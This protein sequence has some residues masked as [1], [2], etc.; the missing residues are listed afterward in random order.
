MG[1]AKVTYK[2]KTEIDYEDVDVR[3][4]GAKP[5]LVYV[6][7]RAGRI[8]RDAYAQGLA[9]GDVSAY[10]QCLDDYAELK[11]QLDLGAETCSDG[12]SA[13]HIKGNMAVSGVYQAY[14]AW[15]NSADAGVAVSRLAYDH[16]VYHVN[17]DVYYDCDYERPAVAEDGSVSYPMTGVMFAPQSPM[18]SNRRPVYPVRV[19]P[20]NESMEFGLFGG[21]PQR[22]LA[23]SMTDNQTHQIL[24]EMGGIELMVGEDQCLTEDDVSVLQE[25]YSDENFDA[26][27]EADEKRFH[28]M[29]EREL[30]GGNSKKRK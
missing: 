4:Q 10:R 15:A 16:S 14:L 8:C 24:L 20:E 13:C 27:Y 2:A 30:S 6:Q 19:R 26:V 21:E 25:R 23:E 22:L 28:E 11:G 18:N 7:E 17:Y 29:L 12:D 1:E 9:T 5:E 3:A